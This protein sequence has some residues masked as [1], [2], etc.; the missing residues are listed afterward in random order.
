MRHPE[1]VIKAAILHPE[2]LVREFAVRY[3]AEGMSSDETVI[4]SVIEAVERYGR[5]AG[6][7]RFFRNAAG[8]TLTAESIE[9]MLKVLNTEGS[10]P[11]EHAS[12]LAHVL[13][14]ADPTNFAL[15]KDELLSAKHF[16]ED[17]KND[18]ARH[19]AM[20][21]WDVDMCWKELRRWAG[22]SPPDANLED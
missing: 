19:L 13:T 8:L 7:G 6:D 18:F 14:T 21:G 22:S 5:E 2:A 4:E 10:L 16:P 17:S 9:W 12:S 11:E 20:V 1:S 15:R 3:F